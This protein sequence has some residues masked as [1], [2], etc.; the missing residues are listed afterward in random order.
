ME[1]WIQQLAILDHLK[2]RSH[3]WWFEIDDCLEYCLNKTMLLSPEEAERFRSFRFLTDQ[4]AFL[5]RRVLLKM[6]IASYMRL[7]VERVR[8]IEGQ[9]RKPMI[10][11]ELARA[12]AGNLEFS[13]SRS[14][15]S[16]A[17][18]FALQ[19]IGVDLEIVREFSDVD[20]LLGS[21]CT[22]D[23]ARALREESPRLFWD[24]FFRLWTGKEAVAKAVGLGL[25]I[26]FSSFSLPEEPSSFRRPALV[27]GL[28]LDTRPL[29]L[30]LERF[31]SPQR[32][33]LMLAHA[34]FDWQESPEVFRNPSRP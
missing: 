15:Q 30:G 19:P 25:S 9:G 12:P 34:A 17:I 10:A 29:W 16:I 21:C 5:A 8:I 2:E 20:S 26:D 7:S 28:G 27:T 33:V 22:L 1:D 11:P 6:L 18:G 32:N 24:R 14:G 3:I 23:E 13:V 31:Q 4:A